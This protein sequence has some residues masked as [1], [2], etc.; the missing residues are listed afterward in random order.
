MGYRVR[1]VLL[2]AVLF[3]VIAGGASQSRAPTLPD[4][5]L[6]EAYHQS[7]VKN[8]LA[9]VNSKVFYGYWC[10]CADG[11]GFG[12]GNSYP[13]LD[14]HQIADALLWLG[15][16][17]IVRANWNFV[18]SYQRKDGLLP[19]AILPSMAGKRIGPEGAQ[20]EVD[21]NGGLYKHWVP[22]NPLEALGS[23]TYIQ[24]A[25][26]IFRYTL[27]REWLSDQLPSINLAADFLLSLTTEEG[28][29][30]GAG[31]YIERP[32]RLES[33]GVTQCYAVDALRRVADLNVVAGRD[34]LA[35]HYRGMA[36]R[37]RRFFVTRFWVKDHFAEY[38]HPER[39]LINLHGLT[40]V[41]WAAIAAGVATAAQQA[42]LWPQLKNE[43]RFHYG[44]MPTGIA[45]LPQTYE[46]WEFTHADRHDVAAMGRVWYLEAWARARMGDAEGLLEGLR[47][48]SKI[49]CENGYSWHE[50][51]HP[52]GKGGVRPGGPDTYCE[53]PA[54]LIRIVQR[55][56]LGVE[57]RLDSS[58]VLAPMVTDNYQARGFGQ[59]L[60][61]RN[62][63]LQYMMKR[64]R[65]EGS[66][67]GSTPQ[68]LGVRF[69]PLAGDRTVR[70]TMN[71][72]PGVA[73]HEEGMV[74]VLL[75][76]TAENDSCAF[77]IR[78]LLK[79]DRHIGSR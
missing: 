62:R 16:V 23:T 52:D 68:R 11:Q 12:Y 63:R 72:R 17:D 47:K 31:Y 60:T 78:F 53:Y 3:L 15:E 40:D 79:K 75:P 55:F 4:Q 13:S 39:G 46:S 25:D 19:I 9:A 76:A 32:T 43:K 8:V 48:V 64:N 66:Y 6:V 73:S 77:E 45:T 36:E 20:A 69:G 2:P 24:N 51:Y 71:G 65:I 10:V 42:I 38:L 74:F 34:S 56:L 29:V 49:G 58:I 28:V 41:D 50:R 21:S 30:K 1:V 22:G 14:G 5:E 59:T 35:Q 57:L 18:R 70:L 61:W 67:H 7:A 44:G 26:I 37:I 54:N 33:D 27:D